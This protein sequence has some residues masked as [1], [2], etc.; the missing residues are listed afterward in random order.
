MRLPVHRLD[1]PP[2]EGKLP[3]P[4]LLISTGQSDPE[5]VRVNL[6]LRMSSIK[7]MKA[8]I[9]GFME[10]TTQSVDDPNVWNATE[11]EAQ[12]R[13]DWWALTSMS[14]YRSWAA[15]L[16]HVDGLFGSPLDGVPAWRRALIHTS[17]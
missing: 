4:L 17:Q 2:P 11:H 9:A 6:T 10:E 8:S 3:K 13:H 14:E 15:A 12:A 1:E 7:P 5:S 16:T